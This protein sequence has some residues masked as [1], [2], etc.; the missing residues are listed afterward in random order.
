MV[1]YSPHLSSGKENITSGSDK[2]WDLFSHNFIL[3]L[4]DDGWPGHHVWSGP[5]TELSGGLITLKLDRMNFTDNYS[6][7]VIVL[8]VQSR[9]SGFHF[10]PVI[11]IP[12]RLD[13]IE[14]IIKDFDLFEIKTYSISSNLDRLKAKRTSP[15]KS[16]VFPA[17]KETLLF[18]LRLEMSSSSGCG[19]QTHHNNVCTLCSSYLI[20]KCNDCTICPIA[21]QYNGLFL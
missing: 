19:L 1:K 17:F 21:S 8:P 4:S 16:K 15:S 2:K 5:T 9:C 7:R 18:Y 14:K 20:V 11:P 3:L 13:R 12:C 10:R 6:K